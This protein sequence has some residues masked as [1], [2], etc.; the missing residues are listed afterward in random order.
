MKSLA[1]ASS[2]LSQDAITLTWRTRRHYKN[3]VFA[4]LV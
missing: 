1:D 4:T 2:L 3:E